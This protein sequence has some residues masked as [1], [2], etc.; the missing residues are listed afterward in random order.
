M[1]PIVARWRRRNECCDLVTRLLNH[2][3]G[4]PNALETAWQNLVEAGGHPEA[5]HLQP[6]IEGLIRRQQALG[7]RLQCFCGDHGGK[8]RPIDGRL[9]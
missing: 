6:K 9:E 3:D 1:P 7:R 5:D 4:D 2:P 8:R